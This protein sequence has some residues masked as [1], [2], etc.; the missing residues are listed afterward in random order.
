MYLFMGIFGDLVLYIVTLKLGIPDLLTP[1]MHLSN[2]FLMRTI[3][4]V[5]I[6]YAI[7][8]TKNKQLMNVKYQILWIFSVG[9]I[10]TIA[11]VFAFITTINDYGVRPTTL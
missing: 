8:E 5:A 6:A 2:S 1:M 10:Q 3:P 7:P 11:V 9:L 4:A